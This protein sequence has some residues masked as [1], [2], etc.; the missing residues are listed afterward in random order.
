[1]LQ[2]LGIFVISFIGNSQDLT[3]T[4]FIGRPLVTGLLLGI[5]FGD[6]RNGLI[7]GATLEFVFM[8]MMGI[9]ATV[10]PDEVAG[11]ILA[12]AFTLTHGYGIEIALTLALPIA[13]LGMIIKNFLY[14][15]FI[16]A[17]VQRADSLADK[18][19]LISSSNMHLVASFSR[20][21]ILSVLITFSYYVGS[22]LVNTIVLGIP[23][24]VVDG[25][26]IATGLLPALGLAMLINMINSAKVLP[27]LFLGFILASYLGMDMLGVAFIGTVIGAV[28][29]FVYED[30]NKSK[31]V[32]SNDEEF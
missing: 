22:D 1:M 18:G 3:G 17:I 15:G 26:A 6:I 20:I 13:T 12:I 25:M 7:I 31:G 21:I 28:L 10:P 2:L 19:K 14:V 30:I 16:P 9:G 27:F 8:G 4:S 23:Q 5:L 24:V 32:T 11:G 29:Y